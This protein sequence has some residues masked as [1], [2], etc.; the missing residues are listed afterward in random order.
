VNDV[1]INMIW[2]CNNIFMLSCLF[3]TTT[4][5]GNEMDEV[6]NYLLCINYSPSFCSTNK[7]QLYDTCTYSFNQHY[8]LIYIFA[9]I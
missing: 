2:C 9:L 6:Y 4:L 5:Q 1:K 7:V 8:I 3:G